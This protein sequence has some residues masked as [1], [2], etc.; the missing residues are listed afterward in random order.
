V[1]LAP[2]LVLTRAQADAVVGVFEE[3]LGEIGA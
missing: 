2:P 1:R 3:S